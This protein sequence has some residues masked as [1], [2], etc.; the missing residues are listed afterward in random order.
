MK[1]NKKGIISLS[2][3]EIIA[4]VADVLVVLSS[5][6][7]SNAFDIFSICVMLI[8]ITFGVA[9]FMLLVNY[10]KFIKKNENDKVTEIIILVFAGI[11]ALLTLLSWFVIVRYDLVYVIRRFLL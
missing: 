5:S 7:L 9:A 3:Y 6:K 1:L 10:Y 8:A 11:I 4:I 2:I